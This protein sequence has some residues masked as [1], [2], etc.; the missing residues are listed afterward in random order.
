MAFKGI[1]CLFSY[2]LSLCGF[3][4][5]PESRKEKEADDNGTERKR[6]VRWEAQC[7]NVKKRRREAVFCLVIL[8]MYSYVCACVHVSVCTG[9]FYCFKWALDINW[10]RLGWKASEIWDLFVILSLGSAVIIHTQT[11]CCL[12]PANHSLSHFSVIVLPFWPS[13][14]H[15]HLISD[16]RIKV[17]IHPPYHHH[18]HPCC[19]VAA[20]K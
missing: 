19:C 2:R 10:I 12:L 15:L 8:W 11:C 9:V 7:G 16:I 3:I 14:H 4:F 5:Y 17:G 6:K 18:H 13:P 20:L 1:S